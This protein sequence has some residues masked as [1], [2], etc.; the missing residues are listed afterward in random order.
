MP[1][2][3]FP[4]CATLTT[5]RLQ[6]FSISPSRDS[7]PLGQLPVPSSPQPLAPSPAILVSV[8][9]DFNRLFLVK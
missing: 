4:P 9:V 3:T 7:V 1:L 2:S 8:S 5:V 6:N